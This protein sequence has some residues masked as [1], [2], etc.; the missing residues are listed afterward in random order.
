MM[1]H[2][3]EAFNDID[4]KDANT[5]SIP[6]F[7]LENNDDCGKT[8]YLDSLTLGFEY[9][10]DESISNENSTP[11]EIGKRG[12]ETQGRS[13]VRTCHFLKRQAYIDL[14]SPIN[15]ISKQHY[16]EIMNKGLM[17]RQKPSNPS[18]NSNFVG[19]V[20]GLK[21]FVGNFTYECSFMIFE[22]TTSIIDHHL[23]EVVFGK[24]FVRKNGLVYDQEGGTITFKKDNEKITF[25]MPHKMEAFNH[26]EFKDVNTNYIPPFFLEN[27]DDR[28]KTYYSNSLILGSEYR[29]DEKNM[30]KYPENSF[31]SLLFIGSG[32]ELIRRIGRGAISWASKKQIF[33]TSLTI[34]YEFVALAT[35][36]LARLIEDKVLHVEGGGQETLWNNLVPKKVNIFMWRAL[37][38]RLPVRVELDKSEIYLDSVLCPFFNWWK[39]RSVNAFTIGEIFAYSEG[40]KAPTSLSRVWKETDIHTAKTEIRRLVVEIECVGK[41]AVAFDKATGSSDGLQPEQMDLN[42]VHALN[43][44]HL[45]EIRVVLSNHEA[46][47]HLSCADPLPV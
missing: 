47:Q 34:E 29:E 11:N 27:D 9:R 7:V 38:G 5:N 39:A 15:A 46:D 44:P 6:P 13:H 14:E 10:E 45:H 24:P 23:G 2:K 17:S 16:K 36:E 8:Y 22:D 37:R 1:P 4:F 31:L 33:I 43:E 20:R 25:K 12:Q 26:I 42:Y 30:I 3:M 21:V 19:R 28:G 35:A 41:I 32:N 18:K 40:V